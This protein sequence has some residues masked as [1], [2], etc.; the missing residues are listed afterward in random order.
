MPIYYEHHFALCII[1]FVRGE[2]SEALYLDPLDH[3]QKKAMKL[4]IDFIETLATS[5]QELHGK[6]TKLEFSSKPK[7]IKLK[8]CICYS[9]GIQSL[10]SQ[11]SLIKIESS[12]VPFFY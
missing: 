11:S 3:N 8:V 5:I 9:L 10:F 12:D 2:I 4:I 6:D 7:I 1:V